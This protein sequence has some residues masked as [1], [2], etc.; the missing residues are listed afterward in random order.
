MITGVNPDRHG[1]YQNNKFE[2]TGAKNLYVFASDV[3]V[4]TIFDAAKEQ[5]MRVSS[6]QW[7]VSAM[8]QA[9]DE[10]IPDMPMNTILEMELTFRSCLK[11]EVVQRFV[12]SPKHLRQMSD[13]DRLNVTLTLIQ[14]KDL[15]RVNALHLIDFDHEQH[16]NGVFSDAAIR[17]LEQ[18]D[19]Y[20]G[21]LMDAIEERGIADNSY[22]VVVSDHGFTNFTKILSPAVLMAERMLT[23]GPNWKAYPDTAPGIMAIY[24]NPELQNAEK[25]ATMSVLED[26]V[27]ELVSHEEYGI[28][29]YFVGEDEVQ[30]A[31]LGGFPGA[32]VIL[33]TKTSVIFSPQSEGPVFR[34]AD[35]PNYVA[36]HGFNPDFEEMTAS[37]IMRG[38]GIAKGKQIPRISVTDLAPTMSHVMHLGMR[39]ME[40]RVLK[41]IF[42]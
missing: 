7:P 25:R 31:H 16:V 37:F 11:G 1:V 32:A 38:P 10:L 27:Q 34:D 26:I 33:E 21:T 12:K 29:R 42:V 5:G 41:E 20:I 36:T 8:A 22:L 23:Q 6:I 4:P 9:P 3:R 35:I 15:P 24:L 40:G 30:R 39:D 2:P 13:K 17:A 14:R 19:A 28:T 18:E